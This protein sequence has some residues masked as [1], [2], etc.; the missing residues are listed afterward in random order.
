MREMLAVT[1]AIVGQGMKDSVA[2]ITD[3]RFSGASHGFM[4]GHTSP[5]AMV[6]G[7]LALVKEGDTIH[8][9]INRRTMTLEISNEEM[10]ARRKSWRAPPP[11]YTR[12]VFAKYAKLV[13]SASK[14]AVCGVDGT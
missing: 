4:I 7:P 11:N 13:S 5:E 12:G 2:L 8:I 9:D 6:G 3:G 1:A 10:E 14:G